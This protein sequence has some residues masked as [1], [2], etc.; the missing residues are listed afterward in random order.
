MRH[1]PLIHAAGTIKAD[2]IKRKRELAINTALSLSQIPFSF[3]PTTSTSASN[4]IPA[5]IRRTS[6]AGGSLP[7]SREEFDSLTSDPDK[8][9]IALWLHNNC[10]P[11]YRKPQWR[12]EDEEKLWEVYN[13]DGDFKAQVTTLALSRITTDPRKRT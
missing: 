12:Q 4:S 8:Y 7:A 10:G 6:L 1:I 3:S 9:N 11:R 13:R 2:H 5:P